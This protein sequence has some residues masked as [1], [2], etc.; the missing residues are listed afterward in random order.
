MSVSDGMEKQA[1]AQ[2]SGGSVGYLAAVTV[3]TACHANG[4]GRDVNRIRPA[5]VIALGHDDSCVNPDDGSDR[6]MK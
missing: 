5:T 1:L 2:V 4:Q 3:A 6:L